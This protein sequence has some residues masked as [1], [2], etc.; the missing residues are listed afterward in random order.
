MSEIQQTKMLEPQGFDSPGAEPRGLADGLSRWLWRLQSEALCDSAMR[1]TGL[2]DFSEPPI[3]PALS[4]LVNSL[5]REASLHPV[6]R[7]LM[8]VHLRQ[9]SRFRDAHP[10][11]AKR[12][13]DVKYGELTS[14]PLAVV[15]RI[16]AHLGIPPRKA[17]TERMQRIASNRTRYRRARSRPALA[18]LEINGIA[19]RRA[20]EGYCARFGISWQENK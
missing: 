16:Y 20:F 1:R 7:F 4:I 18:D 5:E 12:F 17:A 15:R 3:E 13:I 14:N 11:L 6:G 19:E 10:E 8:R 9:L 2:D